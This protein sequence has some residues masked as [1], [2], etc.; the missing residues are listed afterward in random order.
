MKL[1]F[2]GILLIIFSTLAGSTFDTIVKFLSTNLFKWYHFFS[3]GNTFGIIILL[4]FLNFTDGIKKHV[5]LNKKE[6]YIIPIIRGISFIPIPILVFFSLKNIQINLFTT[7]L[8]TMPFFVL[9]FSNIILKEK[10]N[11]ISW[12]SI[13]FG[14]IGVI[15]VLKPTVSHLSVY[16]LMPILV[17]IYHAINF[18]VISKYSDKASPYGYT[19]YF[20]LPLT[21]LS[22]IIFLFD[23]ILPTMKETSLVFCAGTVVMISI[24]LWTTAFHIAGKYSSIIS[25][26]LF[27]QIIWAAIYGNIFFSEKLDLISIIGIIIIV[28]SGI[29]AINNKKKL[30][31][32]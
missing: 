3:I 9:L 10:L 29:I 4:L 23:P 16:I 15:L 19:F 13:F 7:L 22:I 21:F 28:I 24:V 27:S 26:F 32:T 1:L 12:I 25:S 17:A 11:F 20:Y 5:I 18:I 14:F 2:S 30:N 8:M 31:I 6:N